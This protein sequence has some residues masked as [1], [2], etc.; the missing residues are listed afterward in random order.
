MNHV[1]KDNQSPWDANMINDEAKEVAREA[2]NASGLN[3]RSPCTLT[4]CP[5]SDVGAMW[6]IEG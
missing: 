5:A 4:E 3:K 1:V 6:F 2:W